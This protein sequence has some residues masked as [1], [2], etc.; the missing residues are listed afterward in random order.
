MRL[1]IVLQVAAL[2]VLVGQTSCTGRERG[3]GDTV[4][5]WDSEFTQL[6]DTLREIAFEPHRMIEEEK[7]WNGHPAD[8]EL[9]LSWIDLRQR[10][11]VGALLC[12]VNMGGRDAIV[13]PINPVFYQL[14]RKAAN[15]DI[16]S[17]VTVP[18]IDY[19]L[20]KEGDLV[21]LRSRNALIGV[22]AV[23]S[24][25]FVEGSA[26]RV[27]SSLHYEKGGFGEQRL[28]QLRVSSEWVSGPWRRR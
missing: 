4:Q 26:Y 18:P 21:R 3:K 13:V 14:E 16:V 24:S 11:A 19:P 22:F 28:A 2:I 1:P 8:L 5:H 12:V 17:L 23:P 27:V 25:A 20:F 6:Q 9:S 15:G 7:A 10:D